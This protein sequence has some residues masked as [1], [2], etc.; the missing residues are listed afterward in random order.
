MKS[1]H[2]ANTSKD[3]FFVLVVGDTVDLHRVVS[4]V[5][6]IEDKERKIVQEWNPFCG[7]TIN[8]L[9]LCPNPH[10]KILKRLAV[11]ATMKKV[12]LWRLG[13]AA[14]L[15]QA[16]GF[17][18]PSVS[19][20]NKDFTFNFP[21]LSSN[22]AGALASA[23]LAAIMTVSDPAWAASSTAAQIHLNSLPP[24]T[25]SVQ[26]DDLPVV[27]KLLSGTYTKVDAPP[28]LSALSKNG[29]IQTPILIQSPPDKLSAIKN[30]ATGGHL[31]FDVDGLVSTHLNVDVASTQAGEATIRVSSSLIPALPFKNSASGYSGVVDGSSVQSKSAAK[32]SLSSLPPTAI[33]IEIG[34]LPVV[35]KLLSGV[36]TKVG[37][38]PSNKPPAIV[39]ESPSDKLKAVKAAASNGHLEFDVDGVLSTHLDVDIAADKAGVATIKVKSPL[40]PTLPFKNSASS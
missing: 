7:C 5:A 17:H 9:T 37:S 29:N 38:V 34:D 27:G 36:Y 19:T 2:Q 10:P 24:T 35:G 40:I 14:V 39:I 6:V 8:L 13:L 16:L 12:F 26:I 33:D 31:E 4:A 22:L 32:V 3:T 30:A 20:R 15:P 18:L 11:F 1:G 25:I 28:A 21:S 23:S